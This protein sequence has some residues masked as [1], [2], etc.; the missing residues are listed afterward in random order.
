M[1]D[2]K[3]DGIREDV[4][5]FGSWSLL[6]VVADMAWPAPAFV[7]PTV[8]R[9]AYGRLVAS[10]LIDD[11]GGHRFRVHGMGKE[12]EKRSE[13]GRIAAAVR[14]Q[15]N[16]NAEV[17]PSRDE[18]SKAEPSRDD[19]REMPDGRKD[20]EAWML[21]RGFHP[22]SPRQRAFLDGYVR[23]FDLT[24]PERAERLILSNPDD[25]IAALK[26]DL[27]AFRSERRAA[28]VAEE[29]PKPA[30]RKSSGLSGINAELAA[31]YAKQYADEGKA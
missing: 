21:V 11:L 13:S 25:P 16:G 4:R 29:T 27:D 20:L 26:K 18:T 24:G 2:P 14:W 7:P 31:L 10:G 3:F 1:D 28:A 9:S 5:L 19:T 12:R 15:K 30:P 8:P 17:M 6:L 22:P 23:T